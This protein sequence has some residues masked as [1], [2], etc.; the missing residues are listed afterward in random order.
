MSDA[1]FSRPIRGAATRSS[2]GLGCGL[3]LGGL[4]VIVLLSMLLYAGGLVNNI[5]NPGLGEVRDLLDT[6]DAQAAAFR[7]A[8]EKDLKAAGADT[9]LSGQDLAKDPTLTKTLAK[10]AKIRD[11]VARYHAGAAEYDKD[12]RGKAAALFTTE[13][14]RKAGM[15]DFDRGYARDLPLRERAFAAEDGFVDDLEQTA[16]FLKAHRAQWIVR[17]DMV[18]F[19]SQ[20]LLTQFQAYAARITADRRDLADIDMQMQIR[21]NDA[22][23]SMGMEQKPYVVRAVPTPPENV[24]IVTVPSKR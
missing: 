10:I 14:K 1:P 8:E 18:L 19:Y 7:K 6:A 11:V 3:V 9:L 24:T 12:I 17:D 2:S 16:L 22:R 21:R 5:G 20:K 13:A 23:S 15:E 4:G